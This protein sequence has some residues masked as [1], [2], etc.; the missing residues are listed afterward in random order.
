VK[1]HKRDVV[2]DIATT[3]DDVEGMKRRAAQDVE[4]LHE[5]LLSSRWKSL[6]YT[7]TECNDR[8]MKRRGEWE[9]YDAVLAR[10]RRLEKVV[11]TDWV[12]DDA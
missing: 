10:L 2:M 11:E 1:E 12:A 6:G 3:I 7:K 5:A 8:W 4:L 9:A